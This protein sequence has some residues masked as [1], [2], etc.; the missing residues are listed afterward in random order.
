[1]LAQFSKNKLVSFV[2]HDGKLFVLNASKL[3]V[4]GCLFDDTEDT[5]GFSLK[6]CST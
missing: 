3:G 5:S 1:M 2:D 6:S 4:S